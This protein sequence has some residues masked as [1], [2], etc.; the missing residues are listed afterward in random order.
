MFSEDWSIYLSKFFSYTGWICGL[1][2][3]LT[4]AETEEA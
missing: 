2:L 3:P 4:P 1:V